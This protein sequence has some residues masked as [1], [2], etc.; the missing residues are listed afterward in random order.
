MCKMF[1]IPCTHK[2]QLLYAY[3]VT[4]AFFIKPSFFLN[5]LEIVDYYTNKC[6]SMHDQ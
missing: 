6:D 2:Q 1:T 5:T 3:T 4:L